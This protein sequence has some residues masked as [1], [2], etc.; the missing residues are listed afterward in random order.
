MSL[1]STAPWMIS[2]AAS[3]LGAG[4]AWYGAQSLQ[5]LLRLSHA[6]TRFWLGAWLCA[7]LPLAC[8][9][10]AGAGGTVAEA[11][12]RIARC[13]G[14]RHRRTAASATTAC[15]RGDRAIDGLADA[16][17]ADRLYRGVMLA[18]VRWALA[19]GRLRALLRRSHPLQTAQ[20]PGP[21]SHHAVQ[22]LQ[23]EGV[24]LRIV[25]GSGTPFALCRPQPQIIL[26]TACLALPDRTLRLVIGHEAAHLQRRDPSALR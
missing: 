8:A 17:A 23:Q 12:Q 5:R 19:S 20:L 1:S 22:G 15:T 13:A 7:V 3:L 10:A 9:V 25:E 24:A 14:Q 11:G 26:P 16:T 18:L 6:S 2:L 4:L 21:Q